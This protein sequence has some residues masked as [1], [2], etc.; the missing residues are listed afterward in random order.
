MTEPVAEE[1]QALVASIGAGPLFVH[2]DPFRAA[3]LVSRS[4]DRV[5][6]LDSH[7]DVLMDAAGDRGLWLPSFNYDF[8]RTHRF[9]LAN[10]PCQLGPLPEHFRQTRQ[11]WRTPV[12][13]FSVSGVGAFPEVGWGEATDPF[14]P[15]SIFAELEKRDGVIVYY[16]DTFHYNTIV[17]YA[18]RKGGG[19]IY[20]YDKIFRGV[21]VMENGEEHPGSLDYHVR[22]LGSGLDYDWPRLLNEAVEAGVCVRLEGHP[23]VLAAPARALTAHWVREMRDDPFS[24]LDEKTQRWVRL[25]HEEIGRRFRIGDFESPEPPQA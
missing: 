25:A 16:G 8:P 23:E 6:L 3:R 10:D 21:V 4:R 14:G 15:E 7:L 19:P 13:M 24:L 2:S 9:D 11:E 18:E 12:P 20:R 5:A 22:P 1:I 17:H